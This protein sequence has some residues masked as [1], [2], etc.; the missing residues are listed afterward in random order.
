MMEPPNE[1]SPEQPSGPQN[2]PGKQGQ[3]KEARSNPRSLRLL[4]PE[5]PRAK[6]TARAK[7]LRPLQDGEGDDD[8]GPAAA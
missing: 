3:E 2:G 5:N 8:P 4:T 1:T 6:P 7:D